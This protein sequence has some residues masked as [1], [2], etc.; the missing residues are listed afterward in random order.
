MVLSNVPKTRIS[1]TL[2]YKTWVSMKSRCSDPNATGYKYWGGKGIKVCPRWSIFA[3]FLEDMGERPAGMT[4]DRINC[5]GDYEPQNCRWASKTEQ[6]RNMTTTKLSMLKAV[7]IIKRYRLGEKSTS[8]ARDMGVHPDTVEDVYRGR[9]W[10]GASAL[11][12]K[13]SARPRFAH[14]EESQDE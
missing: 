5:A 8:I 6:R 1:N 11:A 3:N 12:D 4:L 9:S 10:V 14:T 2:T 13:D 7:E